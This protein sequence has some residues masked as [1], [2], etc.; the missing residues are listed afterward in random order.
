MTA[1]E[2]LTQALAIERLIAAKRRLLEPVQYLLK[3]IRIKAIE[4][5]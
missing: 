1:K 3:I 2:Y 5:I 4:N